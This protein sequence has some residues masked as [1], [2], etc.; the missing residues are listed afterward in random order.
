[1]KAWFEIFNGL[2]SVKTVSAERLQRTSKG[3]LAD[4]AFAHLTG[5]IM[6]MGDSREAIIIHGY[7]SALSEVRLSGQLSSD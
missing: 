6:Q 4:T 2:L 1:M 3:S 7:I 5:Q